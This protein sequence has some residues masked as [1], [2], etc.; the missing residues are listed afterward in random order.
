MKYKDKYDLI[1]L[2]NICSNFLNNQ[3]EKNSLEFIKR[4]EDYKKKYVKEE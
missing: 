2:Y 3:T 4:V 1:E